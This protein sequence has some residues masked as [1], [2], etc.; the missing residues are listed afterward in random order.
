MLWLYNVSY[1]RGE[2][3][4]TFVY[5]VGWGPN[6][7]CNSHFNIYV[8]HE[9]SRMWQGGLSALDSSEQVKREQYCRWLPFPCH[10]ELSTPPRTNSNIRRMRTPRCCRSRDDVLPKQARSSGIRLCAPKL[11]PLGLRSLLCSTCFR[12]RLFFV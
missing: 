4:R 6:K 8:E 7:G 10:N 9:A 3:V 2:Q 5:H 1:D 12:E 11:D